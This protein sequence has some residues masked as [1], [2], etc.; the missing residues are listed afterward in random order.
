MKKNQICLCILIIYNLFIQIDPTIAAEISSPFKNST[1]ND[2]PSQLI[3]GPMQIPVRSFD[4]T[5]DHEVVRGIPSAAAPAKPTF[6]SEEKEV[7]PLIWEFSLG[8]NY[9]KIKT[10]GEYAHWKVDPS[11]QASIYRRLDGLPYVFGLKMF[12]VSGQGT[13]GH[14]TGNFGF[15][16][17]GPSAG[18]ISIVDGR[19]K[20][21]EVGLNFVKINGDP[22]TGPEQSEFSKASGIRS[23]PPGLWASARYGKML[24]GALSNGFTMG[25][26]W[27]HKKIYTWLGLFTSAWH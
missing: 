16:Y 23:D 8:L 11:T 22:E 27:S 19:Q 24:G 26:Q 1:E 17:F 5:I 14:S 9:T 12:A 10:F 3:E 2:V 13:I 25:I 18:L 6:K 4:Q 15:L 7:R 21:F 20:S